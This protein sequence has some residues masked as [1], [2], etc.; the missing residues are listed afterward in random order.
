MK[1]SV[2]VPVFRVEKY[3]EECLESIR[4]QSFSDFECIVVDDGSDD[5]CPQICDNFAKADKR[6]I[7]VHKENGGLAS[8]RKAGSG[9][10]RGEYVV[11]VDGDDF[12]DAKLLE[13]LNELLNKYNSDVICYGANKYAGEILSSFSSH[14]ENGY[15]E[16]ENLKKIFDACLY[17]PELGGI[18]DGRILFYMWVKCIKR[19]LYLQCQGEVDNSIS[20]GED[21]IFTLALKNRV[22]TALFTDFHGYYYRVNMTSIE[23]SFNEKCFE[24]LDFLTGEMKRI[25]PEMEDKIAV[26]Y[27]YRALK[28]C[29][30]AAQQLSYADYMKFIRGQ[31]NKERRLLVKKA[32]LYGHTLASY[33]K[34]FLMQHGMW[35]TIFLL[36]NTWFK[37]KLA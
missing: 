26:F 32:R 10:A 5:S 13:K 6:F 4:R 31:M 36:A 24:K 18:N 34:C 25:S 1:F 29:L 17:D 27:F 33:T 11:S 12:I 19:E 22:G 20:S 9:I 8:A 28:F 2:V 21:V 37:G 35:R 7:V 14:V 30:M 15:Y 3:L 16:G 23:R